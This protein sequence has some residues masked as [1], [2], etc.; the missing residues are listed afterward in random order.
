MG[1]SLGEIGGRC[2]GNST[3]LMGTTCAFLGRTGNRGREVEKVINRRPTTYL[4]ETS[5]PGGGVPIPFCP[6]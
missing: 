6:E 2:Q 5:E 1:R 3:L 4:W